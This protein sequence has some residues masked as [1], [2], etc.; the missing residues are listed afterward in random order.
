LSKGT[1][2]VRSELFRDIHGERYAWDDEFHCWREWVGTHWREVG[3]EVRLFGMFR[4]FL[5]GIGV[6]ATK[7]HFVNETQRSCRLEASRVFRASSPGLVAFSNGTLEIPSLALRENRPEDGLTFSLPYQFLDSYE[8]VP[9]FRSM[10]DALF[11]EDAGSE[12]SAVMSHIGLSMMRDTTLHRSILIVGPPGCGKTTLLRSANLL[13]GQEADQFADGVIF[14]RDREATLARHECRSWGINCLD[15]FPEDALRDETEFKKISAHAGVVSRTHHEKPVCAQWV[16]KVM[17]CANDIPSFTDR[18]GAVLR[19]LLVEQCRPVDPIRPVDRRYLD[20]VRA[21]L[22]SI[23]G[24]CIW[25]A[26]ETL[27]VGDYPIS[28]AM[29]EAYRRILTEGDQV[30]AFVE[31]C[32]QLGADCSV[33]LRDLYQFYRNWALNSGHSPMSDKKL[34]KRLEDYV[35]WRIRSYKPGGVKKLQGVAYCPVPVE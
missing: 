8:E 33:L 16:P 3:S 13:L 6:P 1:L 24:Y 19:R 28:D 14:S 31:E 2:A 25:H 35:P 22:P 29:R 26:L 7:E 11:G 18:S 10:L 4:D 5:D 17:M 21:E 27:K 20:A 15:E 30:Q 34:A 32:C 12:R 23:A 9:A